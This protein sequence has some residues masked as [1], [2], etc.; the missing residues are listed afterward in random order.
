MA[1]E[2]LVSLQKCLDGLESD[3]SSDDQVAPVRHWKLGGKG[4]LPLQMLVARC[5]AKPFLTVTLF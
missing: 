4:W 2:E 1:E 5:D 3:S